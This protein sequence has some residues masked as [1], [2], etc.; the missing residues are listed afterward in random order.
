MGHLV[1]EIR[2]KSVTILP[3]DLRKKIKMKHSQS[4]QDHFQLL[5]F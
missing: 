1:A 3:Q 2:T 5:R 4:P